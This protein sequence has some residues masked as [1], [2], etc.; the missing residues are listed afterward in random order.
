MATFRSEDK[1]EAYGASHGGRKRA[2]WVSWQNM[3]LCA[4]IVVTEYADPQIISPF[5]DRTESGQ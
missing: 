2:D 3:L 4:D 1:L 5:A